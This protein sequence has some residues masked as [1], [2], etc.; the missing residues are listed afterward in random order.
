MDLGFMFGLLR[1]QARH[2][3]Q[4]NGIAAPT[5]AATFVEEAE[6]FCRRPIPKTKQEYELRVSELG[7]LGRSQL[8]R[9]AALSLTTGLETVASKRLL[10]ATT[11][12]F[13]TR[14]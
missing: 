2:D 14:Q 4:M 1:D 7:S 9:I 5:L 8:N 11:A 12:D 3:A 10:S 6:T 13:T